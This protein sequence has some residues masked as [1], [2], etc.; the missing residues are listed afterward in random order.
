[1]PAS[2][3]PP[4]TSTSTSTSGARSGSASAAGLWAAP[5]VAVAGGVVA[6]L[7]ERP[8]SWTAVAVGGVLALALA[9][10]SAAV[11]R[12]SVAALEELGRA[13]TAGDFTR[14]A[15]TDGT[16]SPGW[17]ATLPSGIASNPLVAIQMQRPSA[18]T[19]SL[20]TY[21]ATREEALAV[22]AKQQAA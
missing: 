19:G 5:V 3:L 8:A 18:K 7:L 21:V 12:R 9:F 16:A 11:A 14:V 22:L 13:G 10:R 4:P 17:C 1:M 2:A 20:V 6:Q 15:E